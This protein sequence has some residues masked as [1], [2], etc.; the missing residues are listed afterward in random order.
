[1][2]QRIFA[3]DSNNDGG[4]A[5]SLG[6]AGDGRL[7]FLSRRVSPVSLDSPA[8][9][10]QDTWHFVAVVHDAVNQTR[11]IYVDG[12]T[13]PVAQDTYTGNW[14][15]DSGPASIGG[16]V[17]GTSEGSPRW[18]FNGAIDEARIYQ[19]VLSGVELAL[20]MDQT[21]V[22]G[23]T[24]GPD[25]PAAA[26][27]CIEP[28][29]DPIAGRLLTKSVGA[30]FI[31]DV[32]ALRDDDNDTIADSVETQFA[33]SAD[34]S[35][36]LE[37]VDSS[38]GA[39]CSALPGLSPAVTL[40]VNFQATDSGLTQSPAL[41]V[42]R[43]YSSVACRVSDSNDAPA[44]VGC[45]TDSF[46]VR[47]ASLAL[48]TPALNN[49]G[50][51]G[52]PAAIVGSAFNLAVSGGA[53]YNGSPLITA[54]ALEAHAGA[55]ATGTLS[56][57]FGTANTSTGIATGS[58]FNYSEVGNFR[59]VANAIRDSGFSAVDQPDDCILG[60][61]AN[62]ADASGR[63]GCDFA[64]PA[65]TAWI[66]RFTPDHFT[67]AVTE[68]G[69]LDNT[70][71]GFSYAGTGIGYLTN[72]ELLIS[73]RAGD[74]SLTL[75]YTGLYNKLSS[76][77]ITFSSLTGDATT[78]GADGVSP[79]VVGVASGTPNL[80]D[81]GD[82]TLQLTLIGDTYTYSRIANNQIGE[83]VSDVSRNVTAVTD[84]E[85][86]T[87]ATGL[88]VSL[89]PAG[90]PIRYGRVFIGSAFGSEFQSLPVPMRIEYFSGTSNR[91]ENNLADACTNINNVTII[92][93]DTSDS[94]VP[95][96]TCI[97]DAAG[98]SGLF[99][100]AAAGN[101]GDQY[102]ATP[103]AGDFNL[104]LAPT[105]GAVGVLQINADVPDWLRF[106][107]RG[108]GFENPSATVTFGRYRGHDRIVYIREVR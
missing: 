37:L 34:R 12:V 95:N 76:A 72:P 107:W 35:V 24:G 73:A 61:L 33:Q 78:V 63:I 52:T 18:R 55:V 60:S 90:V 89:A 20:L 51:S 102:N 13:T 97:W 108:T 74:G 29:Q 50:T 84:T 104:N 62:S 45:S 64:N 77:E 56:G 27:N 17:D 31:V 4:F 83:F 6:D 67:V 5:F 98:D 57:S 2:T 99:A 11:R 14:G 82:G 53:G 103:L 10:T 88:P 19:R 40:P 1:M 46:A 16:E 32:A 41:T 81:N 101:P 91:F 23:S 47:P 7:R 49:G 28:G 36:T 93:P 58:S 80:A 79:V 3:D 71:T 68:A 44:V 94:L 106:D 96:S 69:I 21:H 59:F 9:I 30:S 75:N 92:D 65:A 54:S 86:G 22:C 85:D 43:A 38:S 70:C 26:F 15:T 66:G 39:A 25:E 105:G 48:Q 8:V 87:T 100:C 42:T